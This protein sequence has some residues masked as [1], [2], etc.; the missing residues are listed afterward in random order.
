MGVRETDSGFIRRS[1]DRSLPPE[2]QNFKLIRTAKIELQRLNHPVHL[3]NITKAFDRGSFRDIGV[4]RDNH[5]RGDLAYLD[6]A[7]GFGKQGDA[8]I[9]PVRLGSG[10]G[11]I[12]HKPLG[13]V[14]ALRDDIAPHQTALLRDQND[15]C[16]AFY[17]TRDKWPEL[18]TLYWR[19]F[20]EDR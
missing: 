15:V 9:C 6:E 14:T 2:P 16:F 17:L 5:E 7:T 18:L 4:S 10:D 19:F 13:K 11:I 20:P 3:K 8:C 12:I 1:R